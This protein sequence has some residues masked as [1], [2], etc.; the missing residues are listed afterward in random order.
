[1]LFATALLPRLT[2][3]PIPSL[4]QQQH[5]QRLF[6]FSRFETER[7]PPAFVDYL[8]ILVDDEYPIGHAAV[9]M[10][11]PIVHFI[12]Q[13]RHSQL[14]RAATFLGDGKSSGLVRRLENG[15]A[16]FVIPRLAPAVGRMRLADVDR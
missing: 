10:A 9:S 15:D 16:D 2:H 1:M 3:C 4:I 12:H 7:P 6:H 13:E 5:D 8:S 11:H 14:Q